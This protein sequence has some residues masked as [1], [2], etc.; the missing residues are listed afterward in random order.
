MQLRTQQI[1]HGDLPGGNFETDH[2]PGPT[3]SSCINSGGAEFMKV[4]KHD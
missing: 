1:L 2:E 4:V 3:Q